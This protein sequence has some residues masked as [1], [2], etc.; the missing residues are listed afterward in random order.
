MRTNTDTNPGNEGKETLKSKFSLKKLVPKFEPET[1]Q[2]GP[3]QIKVDEI[4]LPVT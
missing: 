3:S 2:V 4:L 1:K